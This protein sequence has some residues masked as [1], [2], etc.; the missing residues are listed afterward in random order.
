V[1]PVRKSNLAG[2][3]GNGIAEPVRECRSRVRG[4]VRGP[5]Q[6]A[7]HERLGTATARHEVSPLMLLAEQRRSGSFSDSVFPAPGRPPTR[8]APRTDFSFV[9]NKGGTNPVYRKG[10]AVGSPR[11]DESGE[12][13][14]RP[15]CATAGAKDESYHPWS[16]FGWLELACRRVD[17]GQ[18]SRRGPTSSGNNVS[19]FRQGPAPS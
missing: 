2:S 3:V 13:P 11:D 6:G 15:G 16:C 18:R 4:A 12:P 1:L 8:C 9:G 14:F 17:H 7:D 5:L 19:P 10:S